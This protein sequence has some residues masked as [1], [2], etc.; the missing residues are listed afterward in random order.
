MKDY[1]EGYVHFDDSGNAHFVSY[2]SVGGGI[3][4]IV[5]LVLATVF[6]KDIG[7]YLTSNKWIF[8]IPTA[9][10][11]IIRTIIFDKGLPVY[12]RL[13]NIISD[14][15]KT[16]C[17]YGV[18]LIVL[19]KIANA[20]W[21]DRVLFAVFYGAILFAAYFLLTK[22]VFNLLRTT[23]LYVLHIIACL[24]VAAIS[25]V[26][27]FGHAWYW[28]G[29]NYTTFFNNASIVEIDE[30]M[31][32]AIEIPEKIN[33]YTV[34]SIENAFR[35]NRKVTSVKLPDTVETIKEYAF[36]FSKVTSVEIPLSVKK[37]ERY[38]FFLT[39]EL[40]DIYYKGTEEDW[41]KIDIQDDNIDNINI[42]FSN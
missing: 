14:T 18:I 4:L 25:L 23:K 6:L 7:K 26:L 22:F 33:N 29:Y 2:E 17:M 36:S 40:T 13:L 1:E 24:V 15:I 41:N 11:V 21:L 5:V 16:F 8:A 20:H 28:M 12:K 27:Y 42:H 37:I 9:I 3:F 30:R 34:K 19:D 39:E 31:E 10:A 38:A 35:S 32:G